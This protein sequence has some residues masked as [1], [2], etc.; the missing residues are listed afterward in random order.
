MKTNKSKQAQQNVTNTT[1]ISNVTAGQVHTGSGDINVVGSTSMKEDFVAALHEFK[2]EVEYASKQGLPNDTADDIVDKIT[3]VEKEMKKD[4]PRLERIIK[5]LK[6]TKEL[7]TE[8]KGIATATSMTITATKAL[9]PHIEKAIQ[10][11]GNLF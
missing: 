2:K 3:T 7:L 6:N 5:V 8:T 9:I 11:A 10:F 4:K 1:T